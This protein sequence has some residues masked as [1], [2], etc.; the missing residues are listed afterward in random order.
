MKEK[1]KLKFQR[2]ASNDELKHYTSDVIHQRQETVTYVGVEL[3]FRLLTP[4]KK[5]SKTWIH[6]MEK[7][8]EILF[9]KRNG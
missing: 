2:R 7:E 9:S 5:K 6:T 1:K 3:S 4:L 8:H